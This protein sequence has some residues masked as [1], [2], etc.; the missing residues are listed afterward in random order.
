MLF[1]FATQNGVLSHDVTGPLVAVVALSMALTPL[2]MVLNE[3]LLQP[4]LGTKETEERE[5]DVIDEDNPVIIAGFGR[6]GHIVGRFLTANGC[7]TTVLEHDSDHID[8]LRKL[9]I[10]AFY[11]DASRH[12]LLQAAGAGEA[13]LLV[14]AIDDREKTLQIVETCKKQFPKLEILARAYGRFHEYDLLDAGVDRVYRETLESSLSMGVD[15]LRLLGHR[16]Y[17]ARRA[18]N[19]FRKHDE[20]TV[21][22]LAGMRG[23]KKAYIRG[24]RQRIQDM[25]EVMQADFE[26]ARDDRDA[27]WDTSTLRE[28]FGGS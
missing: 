8:L 19:K 10:K 5:A 26:D 27:A 21:R 7:G 16:S 15:A 13:R 14:L 17:E 4:R 9:G 12:D 3:K 20:E 2:L 18:A 25:E 24:A 6:F 1:S 11:G 23:D 22:L 28:E